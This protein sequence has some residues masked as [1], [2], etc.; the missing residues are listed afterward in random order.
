MIRLPPLLLLSIAVC[1]IVLDLEDDDDDTGE[2]DIKYSDAKYVRNNELAISDIIV[3]CF[4]SA[5]PHRVLLGGPAVTAAH[6]ER[7]I[8][9]NRRDYSLLF[10]EDASMLLLKRYQHRTAIRLPPTRRSATKK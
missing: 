2:E 6:S 9:G 4:F 1:W 7:R 8:E 5:V 10:G 3:P